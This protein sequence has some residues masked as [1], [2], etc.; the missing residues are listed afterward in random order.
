MTWKEPLLSAATLAHAGSLQ[1]HLLLSHNKREGMSL[2]KPEASCNAG[3]TGS[4]GW[5]RFESITG[6]NTWILLR[7]KNRSCLLWGL[8]L[9]NELLKGVWKLQACLCYMRTVFEYHAMLKCCAGWGFVGISIVFYTCFPLWEDMA[10]YLTGSERGNIPMR[11]PVFNLYL[12]N[13]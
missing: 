4:N 9:L 7:K 8:T 1:D 6:E 2:R 11:D 3:R 12:K 5:D 13:I 10:I